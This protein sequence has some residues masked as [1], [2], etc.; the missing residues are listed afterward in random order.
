MDT[1][2]NKMKEGLFDSIV[3]AAS[4]LKR[5]GFHSEVKEYFEKD[6]VIPSAGQGIVTVQCRAE[7]SRN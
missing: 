3:L 5:L 6:V 1:R 4:G 7:D 2:I